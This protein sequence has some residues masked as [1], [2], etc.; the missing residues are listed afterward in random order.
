MRASVPFLFTLTTLLS[1]GHKIPLISK[2]IKLLSLWYG[3]I[4]WW[5]ML[6]TVRKRIVIINALIGV[7]TVLKISGFSTTN[8]V[9]GCYMIGH[10]Y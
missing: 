5:E 8:L 2:I 10:T 9:A 3:R 1:Y 7:Y 4:T 6:I